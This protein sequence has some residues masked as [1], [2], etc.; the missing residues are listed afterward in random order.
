MYTLYD[1]G[2]EEKVIKLSKIDIENK[3]IDKIKQRYR[4]GNK[5]PINLDIKM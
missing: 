5:Q 1:L 4:V 2:N 3:S